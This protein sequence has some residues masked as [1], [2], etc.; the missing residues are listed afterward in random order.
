MSHSHPYGDCTKSS[1]ATYFVAILSSNRFSNAGLKKQ[2]LQPNHP[3]ER[4]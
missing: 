2:Q 4:I 3:P 1:V